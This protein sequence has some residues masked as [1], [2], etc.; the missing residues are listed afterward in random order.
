[1]NKKAILIG[2]GATVVTAAL[3]F[4]LLWTPQGGRLDDAR[5]REE[6]AAATNSQL[7]V[8]VARLSSA[9]Q[10]RPEL[11][12][13]LEALRVAVPESPDLAQFLLD[14]NTASTEAGV[15]FISISPTPPAAG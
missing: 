4:F 14:A 2:V 5:A 6:A 3:W 12:A 13:D 10:R 8:K 7:E 1:M 15:D 9:E 11:A